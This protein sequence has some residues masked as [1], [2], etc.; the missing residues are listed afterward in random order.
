MGIGSNEVGVSIVNLFGHMSSF[1]RCFLLVYTIFS[2]YTKG[3]MWLMVMVVTLWKAS[4][5]WRMGPTHPPI[6]WI[7]FCFLSRVVFICMNAI[8]AIHSPCT[9]FT[10][11]SAVGILF[12]WRERKRK[13]WGESVPLFHKG[14]PT[15]KETTNYF[16]SM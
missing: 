2:L 10:L 4:I 12:G 15:L 1:C 6:S 8:I 9:H 7:I 14:K 16:M 3:G 11:S 13:G 5:M